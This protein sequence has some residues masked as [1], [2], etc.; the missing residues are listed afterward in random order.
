MLVAFRKFK[1]NLVRL[2]NNINQPFLPHTQY[3]SPNHDKLSA[4]WVLYREEA[5]HL[6]KHED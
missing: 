3:E 2:L 5:E 6:Q 1:L 4:T